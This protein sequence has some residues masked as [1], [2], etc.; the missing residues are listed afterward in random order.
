[1]PDEFMARNQELIKSL[2]ATIDTLQAPLES[3]RKREI[4]KLLLD[5]LRDLE[6]EFRNVLKTYLKNKHLLRNA[7]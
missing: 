7:S 5:N 3:E 4:D 2:Q 1:M 6:L